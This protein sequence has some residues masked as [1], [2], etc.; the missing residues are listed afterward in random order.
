MTTRRVEHPLAVEHDLAVDGDY[1]IV[2]VRW[3]DV[4]AVRHLEKEAFSLSQ[5]GYSLFTLTWLLISVRKPPSVGTV[6][7]L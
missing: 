7:M 5:D 4:L 2:P 3:R 6:L 1:R